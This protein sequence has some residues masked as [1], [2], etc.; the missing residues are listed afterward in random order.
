MSTKRVPMRTPLVFFGGGA[1]FCLFCHGFWWGRE[2]QTSQSPK[3]EMEKK[4]EKAGS[5]ETP[6][7]R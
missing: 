3:K 6:G 2:C 5:K 7:A 4:D 1:L